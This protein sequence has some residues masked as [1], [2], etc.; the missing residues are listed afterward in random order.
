VTSHAAVG[1]AIY[2]AAGKGLLQRLGAVYC[3]PNKIYEYAGF[4]IPTL[5]NNL[6]GLRYSIEQAG[7]GVCFDANKMSI[8]TAVDNIIYNLKT[9]SDNAYAYYDSVDLEKYVSLV[10]EEL[11]S[12]F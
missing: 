3:A 9:Y 2:N 12:E 4:G 7:A 11:E 1:I 8:L 10:L 6:P 5:G